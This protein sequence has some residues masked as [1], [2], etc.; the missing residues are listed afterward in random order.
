M[1]ERLKTKVDLHL[2]NVNVERTLESLS[3]KDPWPNIAVSEEVAADDIDV[4]VNLVQ[5]PMESALAKILG[6]DLGYVVEPEH[7]LVLPRGQCFQHLPMAIYPIGDL[8]PP[9]PVVKDESHTPFTHVQPDPYPP[10]MDDLIRGIIKALD[11]TADPQVA[12]WS[13]D[14]GPATIRGI[15]GLLMISQTPHGHEKVLEFLN[16][17]RRQHLGA[18]GVAAPGDH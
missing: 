8:M 13:E 3:A 5:A 7:I 4:S 1:L 6:D 12:A 10:A 15:G 2:T 17:W 18:A 11:Q 16:Q 14:G 9:P